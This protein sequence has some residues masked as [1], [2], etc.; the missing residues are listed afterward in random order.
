MIH[1]DIIKNFFLHLFE[2]IQSVIIVTI[3]IL[4]GLQL[5]LKA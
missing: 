2:Y 4:A 5:T 3:S 1:T